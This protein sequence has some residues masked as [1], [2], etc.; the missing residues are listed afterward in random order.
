LTV[1][2]PADSGDG[3]L[4]AAIAAA[5]PGDTIDFKQTI[6][7]ITLTQGQLNITQNLDIEGPGA[8]KLTISGGNNSRIFYIGPGATGV[9]IAGLTITDGRA[10]GNSLVF[11]GTGG[12][13]LNQ[14][15]LTLENDVLS[16]NQAVGDPTK[17]PARAALGSAVGGGIA[18]LGTLTS[19]TACQFV[20]NQALGA[21]NISGITSTTLQPGSAL[22]GGI[23]NPG[24]ASIIDCQF[25]GNMVRGGD[26]NI[27]GRFD[28]EGIGGGIANPGGTLGVTDSMFDHNQAIGG[29]DNQSSILPGAALAGAISGGGRG[30]VNVTGSAFR[31]N[32][33]LGGNGNQV[34]N[35]ESAIVRG[36]GLAGGGAVGMVSGTGMITDSTFDHNQ[37]LAGQGAAGSDGGV[38][39]GGG[40]FAQALTGPVSVTVSGCTVDHN[41]A[42]GGAGG[43]GGNGGDGLG[44]G[45]ADF[46]GATLMVSSTTVDHNKALGGDGVVGGNGYGG[47][48]YNAASPTPTALTTLTLTGAEVQ[49]NFAV[50]GAGSGGS[51]GQGIGGGVYR[52]GTFTADPTT[53]IKKNHA[54][55]EAT[56]D[57][58]P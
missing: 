5:S 14:G 20:N 56:D 45:L 32:Q 27:G 39:V 43:S 9:T 51:D 23:Y 25:T 24:V 49:F 3:T 19:V 16:D 35:P 18:N 42:I 22:G 6:H 12:G 41:A 30:T 57:I 55:Q 34:V 28:S 11:A 33:A 50:G 26:G 54:S 17:T 58:G 10:D 13:I 2:S 46:L 37:A 47:G 4:R 40:L 36:P 53:V 1:T 8:N 7:T 31:D 15:K 29:N 38:G 44:G 21:S 48:L 52:I